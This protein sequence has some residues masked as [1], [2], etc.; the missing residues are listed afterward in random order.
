MK[1]ENMDRWPHEA[2]YLIFNALKK[3]EALGLGGV[4]LFANP[5]TI[6]A[7]DAQVPTIPATYRQYLLMSG[8]VAEIIVDYDSI[9]GEDEAYIF[10]SS[11]QK[12][13]PDES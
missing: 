9:V 1:I 10:R 7:L 3:A 5:T 2:H 12:V 11:N 13:N 8:L 6:K 4:I